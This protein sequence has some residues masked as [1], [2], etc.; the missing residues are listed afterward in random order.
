MFNTGKTV[1]LF[2]G[3]AKIREMTEM[4]GKGFK[5]ENSRVGTEG[6]SCRLINILQLAAVCGPNVK[7]QGVSQSWSY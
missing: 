1:S 3:T 7:L 4:G 5:V 2:E 6:Q